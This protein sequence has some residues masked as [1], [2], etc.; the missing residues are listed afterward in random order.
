MVRSLVPPGPG[1]HSIAVPLPE[2]QSSR[3]VLDLSGSRQQDLHVHGGSVNCGVCQVSDCQVVPGSVGCLAAC[4][5]FGPLHHH[6]QGVVS[7]RLGAGAGSE[8]P[9]AG[10]VACPSSSSSLG[11]RGH[12]SHGELQRDRKTVEPWDEVGGLGAGDMPSLDGVS[13]YLR[14]PVESSL[15]YKVC[16]HAGWLFRKCEH[17]TVRPTKL[18]CKRR[19]C[20]VCGP[21]RRKRIAYRVE[22]GIEML[23]PVAGA[24]WL[25]ATWERDVPKSEAVRTKNRMVEWLRL[26]Q[27]DLEC[28]TIW[29]VT[30]AGRLHVN[31]VMA[32]WS[33]VPQSALS[34][35]WQYFGGGQNVWIKRVGSGVAFEVA[36]SSRRRIGD[37]LA[38]VDQMVQTGRGVSYSRGWPELPV[39]PKVE[40][41]GSHF[42]CE[43]V[44]RFDPR[45]V[46]L[47]QE[48]GL[49]L[50]A[51]DHPGEWK[52]RLGEE[53]SCFEPK[54]PKVERTE[55]W[56][57]LNFGGVAE[58]RESSP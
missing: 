40:L 25:V 20:E 38:K 36:K 5:I 4:G 11:E 58:E 24:G 44:G 46:M 47:R 22:N 14:L 30:A 57:V 51:E 49:G 45:D 12:N 54:V 35:A 6:L 3:C 42:T 33:Y 37:Y 16:P 39:P 13:Q 18:N 32:P 50:W 1:S 9:P 10:V 52:W 28:A 53:C 29:E 41:Q 8:D 23:A 17:G 34:D 21:L 56:S 31:L 55:G 43:W 19:G 15:D 48:I 7:G 2:S 27:P 26:G